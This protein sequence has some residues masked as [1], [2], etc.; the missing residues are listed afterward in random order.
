[1]MKKILITGLEGYVGNSFEKW[2][3][4]FPEEYVVDKI[5]LREESWKKQDF[6]RYDVILHMVG[7]AH[8]KET[9]ENEHLYYQINR[10]LAYEVAKKSKKEGVKHFIF[11]S[12][13]SVYGMDTGIIDF[14]TIPEPKSNYGKSKLQAE[15]LIKTLCT[16]SFK[17]SILRPPMIYGKEC[18]GNYQKLAKLAITFP[19]FPKVENRR[20]MIYIDNLSS[21]IKYIIDYSKEG[22]FFPQNKEYVNT[23]RMVELIAK[24]HKKRIWLTRLFNPFL[25]LIG[26]NNIVKKVFGNLIYQKDLSTETLKVDEYIDFKETI[27]LT[28]D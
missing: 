26:H 16:D 11:L 3:K 25:F 1:M 2:I 10:D 15:E 5:S 18:K 13:M 28:E 12:S 17:V 19:I 4:N 8:I 7:I 22:V 23:S 21:F 14:D 24:T 20:S 27:I 9:K 6:S